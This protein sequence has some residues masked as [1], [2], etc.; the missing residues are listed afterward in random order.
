VGSIARR[1]ANKRD[2]A[3]GADKLI[4]IVTDGDPDFTTYATEYFPEAIDLGIS[5]FVSWS[6]WRD[7]EALSWGH[8]ASGT[9]S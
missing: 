6:R 2:F 5:E 8:F 3:S 7:G 9:R 4:Q 1:D